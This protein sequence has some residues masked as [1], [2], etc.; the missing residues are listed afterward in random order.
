[1]FLTGKLSTK[2]NGLQ[3]SYDNL[4]INKEDRIPFRRVEVWC[5]VKL[6]CHRVKGS[7]FIKM[8]IRMQ[9]TLKQVEMLLE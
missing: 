1:V 2:R 4:V 8:S 3:L 5:A 7:W 9:I 6:D